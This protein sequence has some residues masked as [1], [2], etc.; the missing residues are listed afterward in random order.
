VPVRKAAA[1]ERERREETTQL[2][3]YRGRA[4]AK[5]F[6]ASEIM[7]KWQKDGGQSKW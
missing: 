1:Q 2:I 4:K 7:G 3:R 5:F 6:K